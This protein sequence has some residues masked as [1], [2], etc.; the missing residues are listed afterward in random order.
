MDV[1]SYKE[2]LDNNKGVLLDVRTPE[3]FSEGHIPGAINI[4]YNAENFKSEIEKL[5]K[6]KQYN[7][8]CRSGRRSAAAMEMME[9][10]GFNKVI[11]LEG[12]ILGWQEAGYEVKK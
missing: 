12:G 7:V 9:Q 10:S 2:M 3:E 5:D 1:K 8:Y 4:D 11:N 6:S